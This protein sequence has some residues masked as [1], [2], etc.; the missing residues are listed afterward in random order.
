IEINQIGETHHLVQITGETTTTNN[1]QNVIF[2]FTLE[3][4]EHYDIKVLSVDATATDDSSLGITGFD[5]AD[6]RKLSGNDI[7]ANTTLST[8]TQLPVGGGLTA[9]LNWNV[10]TANQKIQYRLQNHS[11]GKLWSITVLILFIKRSAP[12]T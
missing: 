5:H 11:A 10:D 9:N 8:Q 3:D 2:E 4:G 6:C 12:T 7:E 1:G